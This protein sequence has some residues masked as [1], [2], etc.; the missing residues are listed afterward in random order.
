MTFLT[1]GKGNTTTYEYNMI[2]QPAKRIDPGGK[3]MAHT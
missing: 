1:D 2:G 3:V